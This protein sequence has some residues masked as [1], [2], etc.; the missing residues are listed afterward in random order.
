VSGPAEV[1]RGLTTLSTELLT[2][3]T[4]VVTL[5]KMIQRGTMRSPSP[6]A[7]LF[8]SSRVPDAVAQERD[9]RSV[10]AHA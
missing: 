10:F 3:S 9:M 5:S 6:L 2:P 4:E 1:T 7:I 8:V